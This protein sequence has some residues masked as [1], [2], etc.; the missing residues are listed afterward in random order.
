MQ[1]WLCYCG[2][3][4]GTAQQYNTGT[5]NI[6]RFYIEVPDL[7]FLFHAD[8]DIK[9]LVFFL[10][11]WHFSCMHRFVPGVQNHWSCCNYYAYVTT[12]FRF[13]SLHHVWPCSAKFPFCRSAKC[14]TLCPKCHLLSLILFPV[15]ALHGPWLI[16]HAVSNVSWLS[17][18]F[19]LKLWHPVYLISLADHTNN[20][21]SLQYS[22][23]QCNE[24]SGSF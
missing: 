19:F 1:R 2:Y 4:P 20:Q 14:S 21:L 9:G 24:L 7:V 22:N 15:I 11:F 17:W 18:I 13:I 23:L 5:W 16:L 3:H 6:W 8:G 12:S 10:F